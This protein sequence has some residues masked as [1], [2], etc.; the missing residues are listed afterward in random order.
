M[1]WDSIRRAGVG[2]QGYG[3]EGQL[4]G[5][6]V[7]ASTCYVAVGKSIS[8]SGPQFPTLYNERPKGDL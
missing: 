3:V 8:F 2:E 1:S 5:G 7:S 4:A 6:L